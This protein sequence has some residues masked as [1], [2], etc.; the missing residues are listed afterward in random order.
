MF[1]K[2]AR[3]QSEV[4]SILSQVRCGCREQQADYL[5]V[6]TDQTLDV[7]LSTFLAARAKRVK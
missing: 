4:R 7:V 1:R 5:L 3:C 2:Y 6:R